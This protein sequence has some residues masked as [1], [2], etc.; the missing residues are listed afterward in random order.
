MLKRA[1]SIKTYTNL[2]HFPLNTLFIYNLITRPTV[3]IL[4]S[5]L[6]WL[7]EVGRPD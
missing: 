4:H 2:Y 5:W 3:M 6:D 7:S 1:Y